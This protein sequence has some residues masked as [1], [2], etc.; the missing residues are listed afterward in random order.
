MSFLNPVTALI[1]AG[2]TIPLLVSLYFLKLRRKP[3]TVPSTLLWKK[4]IQD[5]QVNA[6]FQRIRNNL[7][8]WLQ[9]LLL[10]LLLLAMARPTQRAT[11]SPGERVVIV[12]DQS[13]SM[14]TQTTGGGTRLEEAKERALE[15]IDSLDAASGGGG[16]S[17]GAMVVG[18]AERAQVLQSFTNDR[19]LLRAAVR[20]IGA[21]DQRSRIE[22]A[23]GLIQPHTSAA[24]SSDADGES[25]T[26]YVFS[27]GR[28][29][30][31][32]AEA[33][34]LPGATLA[35][36]RIGEVIE[37]NVGIVSASAR[38]DYDQ[39][40]QVSVFARLTN[41]GP[42]T[43]A[44]VTL[45]VDGRAARTTAVSLPAAAGPTVDDQG[46]TLPG[47]TG[48]AAVTFDVVLSGGAEIELTHDVL[49]TLPVDDTARLQLLPAQRLS[50]LLVTEGNRY[51][52]E[53]IRAAGARNL[54][55]MSPGEYETLP[56]EVL[57]DGDGSPGSDGFDVVVFDR[58][59]PT[60]IPLV[61]SLSFG[62][63]V[64]VPGLSVR[65]SAEEAPTMQ[66]VLTWTRDHPLMQ[67]VVLD[68]VTLRRPGRLTVPL[69]AK[70]LA[71]GLAGPLIAETREAQQRH[72]A[73]SFDVLE[74]RWPHHW[75]FQVFMVNAL[76][77]LGLSNT[78]NANA[79][80]VGHS[81]DATLSFRAGESATVP[82]S[83]GITTVG[84]GGPTRLS[85]TARAGRATLPAFERVG[86]YKA[87]SAAG[88]DAPLDRLAVNLLDELESDVRP[89]ARLEI[90]TGVTQT[91]AEASLI[92][93]EIWP[94][95]A[96]AALG[97]LLVE[98]FVYT[99]RMRV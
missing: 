89:A 98:W 20:S 26:V 78:A 18:F 34:A 45:K 24:A 86:Y 62:A 4:A 13:G 41:T 47:A 56:P 51:L 21:T 93:K 63:A 5:L 94:W 48:E 35:F 29:H 43:T 83:P 22:P 46:S 72:V 84:Y 97:L 66:A 87:D 17:G 99:R 7:L 3:M 32:G 27:D 38:R 74:S 81:V 95:F 23:L 8:L 58:Y 52:R 53:A 73:V 57:R 64:P 90:G 75:S 96:W 79:G 76:E 15:L 30:R 88:V 9:L 6:P 60:A 19:G 55:L 39:P 10:A 2:I 33:L 70:V 80:E 42:A 67:Y 82:V 50:V 85:A 65:A 49:D 68:D 69:D 61:S 16:T 12:I 11:V 25:L 44:N 54:E 40:S 91:T 77:T 31:D 28:V 36:E 71:V 37:T 92:R 59:S 1:A 14:N